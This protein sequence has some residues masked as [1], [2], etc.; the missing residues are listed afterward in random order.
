MTPLRPSLDS[1]P[2]PRL[3]VL[4]LSLILGAGTALLISCGGDDG[5]ETGIPVEDAD[6]MLGELQRARAALEAGDCVEVEETAQ[7]LQAAAAGLAD[8][9]VDAEVREGIDQGAARLAE[10]ANDS[11]QCEQTTTEDTTTT[12]ETEPTTETTTPTTT[13]ETTTTEE[14]TTTDEE[15]EPPP[16][17]GGD[18]GENGGPGTSPPSEEDTGTGGTGG[19]GDGERSSKRAKAKDKSK[20]KDNNHKHENKD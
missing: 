15:E 7:Q 13:T 17:D 18:E 2:M 8:D 12:E 19:T 14:T 16:E 4:L 3:I 5:P 10:L 20:D 1:P 9:G 6:G 11:S